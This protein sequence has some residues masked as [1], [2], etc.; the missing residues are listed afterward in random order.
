MSTKK[1]V[2]EAKRRFLETQVLGEAILDPEELKQLAAEVVKYVSQQKDSDK[3]RMFGQKVSELDRAKNAQ[4][5]IAA[6]KYKE[7]Y[8]AL[9][10]VKSYPQF[11]PPVKLDQ[12]LKAYLD[13]PTAI[14]VGPHLT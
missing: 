7:A 6:G 8:D 12:K 2:L 10:N 13:N 1:R 3:I 11:S 4:K 5:L 14:K 9:G